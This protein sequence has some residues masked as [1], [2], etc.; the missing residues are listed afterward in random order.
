VRSL[1]AAA[2]ALLAACRAA[3]PCPAGERADGARA[4]RVRALLATTA[5]GRGLA[6]RTYAICFTSSESAL[7]PHRVTLDDDAG[8]AENAARLGHLLLHAIDP[9][10]PE[11]LERGH[12]CEELVRAAIEAEAR[13]Y[14]LELELRRALALARPRHAYRFERAFWE[15]APAR[16]HAVLRAHL[17]AHPDGGGGVPGLVSAYSRRCE[18]ARAR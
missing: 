11:R 15:A 10:L 14:A 6:S 3:P 5:A 4:D 8:D 2:L 9:P 18:A 16:R 1:L 17:W 13:G 7:H 12:R